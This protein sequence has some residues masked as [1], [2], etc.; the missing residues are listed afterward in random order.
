M[1]I[2]YKVIQKIFL[3]SLLVALL[4]NSLNVS[5]AFA[6]TRQRPD[7]DGV[8]CSQLSVTEARLNSG[9]K[10]KLDKISS[11]RTT[12]INTMAK[13]FDKHS[14]KLIEDR[15]QWDKNRRE[16]YVKLEEKATTDSQKQAV[17]DFEET[18]DAAVAK[19]RATVDSA[20][21]AF[22]NTINSQVSGRTG[23]LDNLITSYEAAL[24]DAKISAKQNCANPATVASAHQ[25][26]RGQLELA[27]KNLQEGKSGVDKIGNAVSVAADVKRK[28]IG[29]AISEFRTTLS[30]A[31]DSLK[32]ALS[33]N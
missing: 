5:Q 17:K 18:V 25:T 13:R 29:D 8:F 30:R 2:V 32:I 7:G 15:E 4:F 26:F 1:I 33:Q 14:Q 22:R 20:I 31:R 19:R 16:H 23:S 12:H 27:R 24:S 3:S 21:A 10:S 9:I 28:T 11:E 6:E